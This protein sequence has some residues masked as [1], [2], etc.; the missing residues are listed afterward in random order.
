M[1]YRD[2][3]AALEAR[4][5]DLRA[6]LAQATRKAHELETLVQDREAIARELAAVEA[7]L[8]HD[9]A[10]QTPLLGSV[11]VATP[12][13]ASWEAMTGDDQVRFCGQCQKNV[14]NLSAMDRE[15]AERLLARREGSIC[16]RFYQRA[17]GTVM[18]AD[19][20]V[21]VRR[22][23]RR[24]VALTV[25]GAGAMAAAAAAGW[26]SRVAEQREMTMGAVAMPATRYVSQPAAAHREPGL[27]LSWW[28]ET[29]PAPMTVERWRVYADHRV[30]HE[31]EVDKGLRRTASIE[32]DTPEVHVLVAIAGGYQ[33]RAVGITTDHDDS[34]LH[35]GW[36]LFGTGTA[37]VTD[38]DAQVLDARMAAVE[39]VVGPRVAL[40]PRR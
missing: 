3:R 35:A 36:E 26:R 18:T 4:R 13:T 2:D 37:P 22:R 25:V 19:C 16:V 9:R 34:A 10:R 6:E 24:R 12:C 33:S 20:P 38:Y 1:A 5:E 31:I 21:G 15:E 32:A 14:Y 39:Q 27:L 11:R 40:P 17:D 7:R 8:A 30:E 23:R 29:G 28:R